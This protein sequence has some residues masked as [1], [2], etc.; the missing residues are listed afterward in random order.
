MTDRLL[1]LVILGVA[2]YLFRK[3]VLKR[4]FSKMK[5]ENTKN[6]QMNVE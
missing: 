4:I 1:L 6:D 5:E 2:W 3:S